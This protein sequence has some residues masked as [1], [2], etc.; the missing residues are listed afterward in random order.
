MPLRLLAVTIDLDC[1]CSQFSKGAG[2]SD[3]T[4]IHRYTDS[5]VQMHRYEGK[6]DFGIPKVLLLSLQNKNQI[7]SLILLSL[8]K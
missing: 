4:Q 7:S 2:M 1:N 6:K 8:H 3:D 5:D